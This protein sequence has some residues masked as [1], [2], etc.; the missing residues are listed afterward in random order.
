MSSGK[1]FNIA[2][3]FL[4]FIFSWW[5]FWKSFGYENGR[6]RIARH[7]VGDFGHHL[8]IIR[9][10]SW[11]NNFPP[12]SPFFPGRPL[13]YHWGVDV[14]V[15]LLERIGIR[16]DWAFNGVSSI[17]M[18]ALL[19]G[20]YRLAYTLFKNRLVGIVAIILFLF[21]ST[22]TIIDYLKNPVNIWR[23]PD[24]IH[25]GPFDG[26]VISI[27]QT[28]N[29]Y[30]NQRHLVVGLAVA[31][32][33]LNSALHPIALGL[34]LGLLYKVHSLVA[35]STLVV[36]LLYKKK[37]RLLFT[38]PAIFIWAIFILL[39][40]PPS[41]PIS[42][43][44]TPNFFEYWWMNAGVSLILL[45]IGVYLAPKNAKHLFFSFLPLFII[46]NTVK[47]SFLIEH[48]H[49]LISFFWIS[50][51]LF[52]AYAVVKLFERS[53]FLASLVLAFLISSGILNL[54]AVKNDY[55]AYFDDAPQWIKNNTKPDSIFLT[56]PNLY[57]PAAL[58]G[59]FTYVGPTSYLE[60]MGIDYK[61]RG[62][63]RSAFFDDPE[64]LAKEARERGIDYVILP[65]G[66]IRAI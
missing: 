14:F 54:M 29:P 49:S 20:I 64:G 6:F 4:C 65:D 39:E 34:T 26:S 21:P 53:K 27:L 48:N 52:V 55:Q 33:V 36:I 13:P 40:H 10:I 61:E 24:Y 37:F 47:L 46:A 44:L 56:A 59:R 63:F 25:K 43:Y 35:V 11:G 60:V 57:D 9:S 17:A 32:F 18:T 42:F 28:L 31:V 23:L 5:L 2:L 50:V 3:I 30:L 15:G 19:Y 58:A 38:A 7:Q 66:T 51:A 62:V 12:E 16:I 8:S 22:L 1:R 45:P 41:P